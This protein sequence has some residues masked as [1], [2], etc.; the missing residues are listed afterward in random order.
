MADLF[1]RADGAGLSILRQPL[2]A[3]DFSPSNQSYDPA[4][5]ARPDPGLRQFS[6]GADA[7]HRPAAG[8]SGP[9]AEPVA[10]GGRHPVV[11]AGAG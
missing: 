1:G 11:R 6:L 8:P 5:Q 7:R 2:G 9:A 3:N 4:P 10:D